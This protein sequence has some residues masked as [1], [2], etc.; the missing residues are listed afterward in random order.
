MMGGAI[1]PLAFTVIN[2]SMKL[3][4]STNLRHAA[5]LIEAGEV[6]PFIDYKDTRFVIEIN[7]QTGMVTWTPFRI[8]VQALD[9]EYSY[10]YPY[11]SHNI[12]FDAIFGP[13]SKSNPLPAVITEWP[14][15]PEPED[16]GTVIP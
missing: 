1:S 12:I 14:S 6:A 3:Q 4:F 5:L 13:R 7:R 8:S 9:G 16:T 11:A 15:F 2:T 10:R